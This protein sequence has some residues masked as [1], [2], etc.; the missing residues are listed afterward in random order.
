MIYAEATYAT[1]TS[2][3]TAASAVVSGQRGLASANVGPARASGKP[4]Q[5]KPIG[6]MAQLTEPES[7]RSVMIFCL[8]SWD[9]RERDP[10][11][12]TSD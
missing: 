2:A 6:F 10:L 9:S 11:S 8:T 3:I 4:A 1:R 12:L 7:A 5:H